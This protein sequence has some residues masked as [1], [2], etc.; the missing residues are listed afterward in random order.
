MPVDLVGQIEHIT[1][2]SEE[3]GY[4]I[5]RVKVEGRPD[6]ITVVG[7]L[8]APT[9]GEVLRMTGEWVRHPK[10][11]EQFR[12]EQLSK[13]HSRHRRRYSNLP[14]IRYDQRPRT[15]NGPSDR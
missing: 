9:P 5:A 1:Y 15:G 3:T 13:Q 2:T 10:Y 6:P 4:T 8:L 14:W 11:G 7:G 12:V